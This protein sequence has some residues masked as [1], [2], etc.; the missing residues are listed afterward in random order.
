MLRFRAV[1]ALGAFL[2]FLLQPMAARRLLP[3]FG[4]APSVWTTCLVFFQAMLLAGYAY[5]HWAGARSGRAGARLHRALLAVSLASMPLAL[6]RP[7]SLEPPAARILALLAVRAGLPLLLLAATSPLA[8]RWTREDPPYRLYAWSNAAALVALVAYPVIVE[9]ALTVR[10]QMRVWSVGY[11]VFA[12]LAAWA[13]AEPRPGAHSPRPPLGAA[14]LWA[15]LAAA[16]SALLVAATNQMCREVAS[17]PFLWVLPL[18]LYLL[19]WILTFESDRW[20]HRPSF[21]VLAGVAAAGASTLFVVGLS[22]PLWVHLLVDAAALFACAVLCHGE[23]ARSR[24]DPAQ[25]TGFYLAAAAG[26]ATGGAAVGLG[27]PRVFTSYTEFPLVLAAVVVAV[28]AA[29]RR[30]RYRPPLA[31]LAALLTAAGTAFVALTDRPSGQILAARRDFFGILRV[32]ERDHPQ[33]ARRVLLHGRVIHGSQ[34]LD[35]KKASWPTTYYGPESAAGKA[36][37]ELARRPQPMRVGVVGLGVGTLAAYGRPG[38]VIRFYEINPNV[39]DLAGRYF[40]Y[41]KDSRAQVEIALGDARLVLERE[42]PQQYDLL[43][44]DAFSSDAIPVHLL[45]AECAEIYRRHL[46][47]DGRLLFHISN[48]SLDLWPVTAGLASHLGWTAR[49]VTTPGDE[50]RGA[51]R[52]TWAVLSPARSGDSAGPATVYWTDDFSSLWPVLRRPF[53]PAP[54]VQ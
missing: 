25:L 21:A 34:F 15:A 27:A 43:A 7:A 37:D 49:R 39:A 38:D 12:L 6:E 40:T 10:N 11:A 41:L 44:V 46:R 33:G 2:L 31:A 29:W 47:P 16:P 13:A 18:A 5:A 54:S 45:T 14:V 4:G 35:W 30:S 51:S 9:P 24:P 8:Q 19:S 22:A 52:A 26:G 28:L 17:T 23:L 32:A 36:L 3:W 1:A 50:A 48:Q 42:S 53:R 20:Y